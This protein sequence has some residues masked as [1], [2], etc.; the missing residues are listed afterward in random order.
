M[1]SSNITQ[2][3]SSINRVYSLIHPEAMSFPFNYTAGL[4]LPLMGFWNT[5]IYIVTSWDA[6]KSLVSTAPSRVRPLSFMR[7]AGEMG[8]TRITSSGGVSVREVSPERTRRGHKRN[9]LSDSMKGL[10][11][12][13]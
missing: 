8:R 9:S 5:I 13:V 2:V 1:N 11:D 10:A 12:A 4:V 7:T 6:V 3:P